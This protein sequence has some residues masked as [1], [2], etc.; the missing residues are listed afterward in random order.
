MKKLFILLFCMTCLAGCQTMV[1]V[2]N[3]ERQA[4]TVNDAQKVEKAI[5]AGATKRGWEVAQVN[6][7]VMQATLVRRAHR[8]RVKIPYDAQGYSILYE[9]S[10]NLSYNEQKGTIHPRYN[11]WIVYLNRSINEMLVQ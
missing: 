2:H 10:E 7:G 1:A 5:I 9:D 3:V 11:T 4:V 6:P 8:V